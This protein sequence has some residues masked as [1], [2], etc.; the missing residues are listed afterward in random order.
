MTPAPIALFAYN[1]P[2]HLRRTV[3]ALLSNPLAERSELWVFCDA[4]R[5]P[6]HEA[7]VQQVRT[8]VGTISGF[9]AIHRVERESNLGLARS[10]EDGVGRLCAE[11]GRAI[12]VEDDIVV[13]P[14]FLRFLNLALE[15]YAETP[16]VMQVSGYM[17]PGDHTDRGDA[18]FLPLISCWGWATWKR[19]WDAYDPSAAGVEMLRRDSELQRRFNL[20]GAYDY[21]GM[22][23]HQLAGGL[24]SWGVRWLL[25]VFLADG[26]VLYPAVSLV[27]NIGADG[28]GT[29]GGGSARLH[30]AA[31]G[32]FG[33]VSGLRLPDAVE[34][35]P[36][37]LGRVQA[38]LRGEQPGMVRKVIE[39]LWRYAR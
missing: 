33:T 22:L 30:G 39:R 14:A 28:T 6:A 2:E 11:R 32:S 36:V 3:D 13:A 9:A 24:D 15:R 38:L 18:V 26:V 5:N 31:D 4:A 19:A 16:R 7:S 23:E 35:D 8:Y 25:C 37:V 21:F 17:F 20:D 27:E 29:H 34:V 12:V 10:I 1:R